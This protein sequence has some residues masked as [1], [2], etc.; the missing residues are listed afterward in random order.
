MIRLVR[1][2]ALKARTVWSTWVLL[3]AG[4]I[5]SALLAV[6]V[7]FAPHRHRG[8]EAV[9]FP[10]RGTT[11]WFDDV[12]SV[13]VVAVDFA[14]VLG[15]ITMTGEYRHKTVT[16]TFL[17]TPR[18][19]MVTASK[20][21]L[22]IGA[23]LI[24]GVAAGAMDLL[25]GFACVAGGVGNSATMLGEFGHVWPG[26]AAACVAFGLYGVGLGALL[27]NQV[28]AIVTGIGFVAVVEPILEATVPSVG[29]YLPGAA[30][31]ALESVT[32]SRTGLGFSV[33][34]NLLTWWEGALVLLAY[35]V[36][37]AVIGSVLTMRADVT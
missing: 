1:A 32:A 15:V 33:L 18:R 8:L 14:M 31:Q 11:G 36:V 2:E 17:S 20:L 26:A 29:R 37:F 13:M 35:G 21:V 12:F 22:C 4:G 24:V 10:G 16:S 23:G 7:G 28:V 30:A 27:K 3:A 34:T 19:G 5:A 6:I 25:F 9:L